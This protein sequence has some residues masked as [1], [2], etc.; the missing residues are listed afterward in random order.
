MRNRLRVRATFAIRGLPQAI[1]MVWLV[2][3]LPER[4]FCTKKEQRRIIVYD[5]R[6]VR[7]FT[8]TI[9]KNTTNPA[10]AAFIRMLET[11]KPLVV[12]SDA[13]FRILIARI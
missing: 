8:I 3:S 7:L 6:T 1:D 10:Y 5:S 4:T 13:Q 11:L 12:L 9:T 2:I